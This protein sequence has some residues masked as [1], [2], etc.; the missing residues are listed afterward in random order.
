MPRSVRQRDVDDGGIVVRVRQHELL[1]AAV[2]RVA[3]GEVPRRCAGVGTGGDRL[4]GG[5]DGTLLDE[6]SPAVDLDERRR[7]RGVDEGVDVDRCRFVRRHLD[8]PGLRLA[9]DA[10]HGEATLQRGLGVVEDADAA[11]GALVACCRDTRA[12]PR[13]GQSA[14]ERSS[15]HP[16]RRDGGEHGVDGRRRRSGDEHGDEGGDDR[17]DQH[18]EPAHDH[19]RAS[20]RPRRRTSRRP[21]RPRRLVVGTEQRPRRSRRAFAGGDARR[22]RAATITGTSPASL[23]SSTASAEFDRPAP[24]L[25]GV[26]PGGRSTRARAGDSPR[27]A[28]PPTAAPGRAAERARRRRLVAR[29][30]RRQPW[31]RRTP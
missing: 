10:E 15:G 21:S 13:A 6:P 12:E 22:L 27:R 26:P 5:I 28:Q 11:A 7:V 14:G 18:R 24:G 29:L 3:G 1:D 16:R 23:G 17:D 8:V 20:R 4:A 2:E 19:R 25:A 9:V 30:G 31:R